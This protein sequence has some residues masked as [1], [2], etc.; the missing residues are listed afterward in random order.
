MNTRDVSEA[1]DPELRGS[2][3]A[4]QRAALMACQ[5]GIQTNTSLVIVEDGKVALISADELRQIAAQKKGA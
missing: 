3:A 2:M 5:I 4:L 1:K